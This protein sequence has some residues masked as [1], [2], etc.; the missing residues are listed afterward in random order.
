MHNT[1]PLDCSIPPKKS[2]L[3]TL[4][5]SVSADLRSE[6]G[7]STFD[8]WFSEFKLTKIENGLVTLRA[9]G[10]MYSIWV[11]ENFKEI[12]ISIF[13]KYLCVCSGIIFEVTSKTKSKGSSSAKRSRRS[14]K[15][16]PTKLKPRVLVE[17][18]SEQR[19]LER[20]RLA[21]LVEIFRFD[22]FVPGDN[23][24]L[25]WAAAQAVAESPGKTYQPLFFHSACGL[26]KTHLLHGIGWESLRRRPKSKIIFVTAEQFA[27][28]YI[29]AIQKNSLVSFRKKYREADL[30]L[31][32]DVQFLG[33]KEGL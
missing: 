7:D 9:P 5:N 23:S 8:L 19:L 12:L 33:R 31:I 15:D 32:D 4:W 2:Q 29:D 21:G 16:K 11:E 18:V 10:S 17:K 6:L 26:G 24:E 20:G 25:A 14:K 22:N 13:Q 1:Q 3:K 30:L 27:N 28:D